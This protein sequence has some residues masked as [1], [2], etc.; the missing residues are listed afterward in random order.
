MDGAA[1]VGGAGLA[2]RR[3]DRGARRPL[4]RRAGRA[5]WTGRSTRSGP[6]S[7]STT[8]APRRRSCPAEEAAAFGTA[9]LPDDDAGL[10][11]IV[12]LGGAGAGRGVR[13]AGRAR[14]R[15]GLRRAGRRD[16]QARRPAR[17]A[18]AAAAGRAAA[19]VPGV[20]EPPRAA[21]AA[22]DGGLH[23]RLC[24]AGRAGRQPAFARTD[25]LVGLGRAAA[26]GGGRRAR[27]PLP[28][29]TGRRLTHFAEWAGI[30]KAHARALWE[31]RRATGRRRGSS[32]VRLLAPGDPV[33]LGRDREALSRP[34]RARRSGRDRGMGPACSTMA[35]RS[36]CGGRASKGPGSDR[37][38]RRAARRRPGRAV[39]RAVERR[40]PHRG[41]RNGDACG[42]AGSR[43]G[44]PCVA[45]RSSP[46]PVA[47]ERPRSGGTRASGR[48]VRRARRARARPGWTELPTTSSEAPHTDRPRDGWVIDGNYT[49][50]I[51]TLVIDAADTVVWLDLPPRVWLPRLIR[52]TRRRIRATRRSGTATRS[53]RRVGAG[54]L[55]V[56]LRLRRATRAGAPGR[57]DAADP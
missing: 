4:R 54:G 35:S 53:P 6:S 55:A 15:R 22:G 9:F 12:G 34:G 28:A 42:S 18:A 25:Q 30:G 44:V 14:G 11:A 19:V 21:R 1:L 29:H 40:A 24:I 5:G 38:R 51:G 56:R 37:D 2:A 27:A 16:A 36:R 50:K 39:E 10:K 49:G 31:L 26:R 3:G 41:A 23:G 43:P 20:Q 57:G 7:R 33:L 48:A 8:R 47:T 52:R 17:G 45:S 13:G 46:R 32:G